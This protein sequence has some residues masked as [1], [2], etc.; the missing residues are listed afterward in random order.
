VL[1]DSYRIHPREIAE[2][3]RQLMNADNVVAD[4][5]AVE[6]GLAHVDAGGDFADGA[7]AR[8]GR[9]LGAE[10]FVWFDKKAVKLVKAQGEA[11]GPL[12][13]S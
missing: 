13:S 1:S 5:P 11:A 9:W 12:S 2:T 4:R 10:A 3:I 7:I 8:E 6:A